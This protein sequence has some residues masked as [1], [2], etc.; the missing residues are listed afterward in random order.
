MARDESIK[1]RALVAQALETLDVRERQILI[2]R[3]L[4][5]E[6]SKLATLGERYGVSRERVRQIEARALQKLRRRVR[7]VAQKQGIIGSDKS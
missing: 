6:P 1:R 7:D 4:T 5:D 3:Q 2:A